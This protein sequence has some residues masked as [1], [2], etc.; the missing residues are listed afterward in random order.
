MSDKADK[1]LASLEH[2]SANLLAVDAATQELE[3][4]TYSECSAEL[5]P[6]EDAKLSVSLAYSVASLF[7]TLQNASG[8]DATKHQIQSEL[9][10]I[11]SYVMKLQELK[12]KNASETNRN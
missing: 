2:L 8:I 12:K 9:S 6:L 3:D 5:S 4:H 10:G 7:F 1:A 11:K